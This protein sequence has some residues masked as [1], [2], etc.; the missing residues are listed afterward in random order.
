V[1]RMHA[2]LVIGPPIGGRDGPAITSAF[3]TMLSEL[4]AIRE[5]TATRAVELYDLSQQFYVT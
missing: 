3:I 5:R 1:T 4:R 2:V